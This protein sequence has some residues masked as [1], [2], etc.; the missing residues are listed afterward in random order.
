MAKGYPDYTYFQFPLG[1]NSGGTGAQT[2]TNH[3]VLLGQG[4]NAII[5]TAVGSPY[6]SLCVPPAGG[7]PAF[8]A[9]ELDQA[10]AVSGALPVIN[11][12]TGESACSVGLMLIGS[13]VNLA[14][15]QVP[16]GCAVY[17][18]DPITV[19]NS[20]EYPIPF[21]YEIFDNGG[22]HTYPANNTRIT[23]GKSGVYAIYGAV[24]W[25]GNTTGLRR[26]KIRKNGSA[27]LI[28]GVNSPLPGNSHGS[29]CVRS[30]EARRGGLHRA[31]RIPAFRG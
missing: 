21:R 10:A 15:W 20:T 5:A 22:L 16:D 19:P 14:A 17:Y 31:L 12:G 11:G 25:T 7:D 24:R 8:S 4:T 26:V 1:V 30:C 9:V 13:G 3:G 29:S 23:I 18:L 6:Q 2:L 28:L 27:D